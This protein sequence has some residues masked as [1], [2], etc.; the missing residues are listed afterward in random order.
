MPDGKGK[1]L[2]MPYIAAAIL[3]TAAI[4]LP[5]CAGPADGGP[6]RVSVA[7]IKGPSAIGMALF[8]DGAAEGYDCE[9]YTTADEVVPRLAKGELDIAAVPANLSSIL[10][11]N[12]EGGVRV[13]AI[14]TMGMTYV[15]ERGDSV[16]SLADL[17]GK[18]VYAGFKGK[19][20]EFDLYHILMGNGIDPEGDLTIEWKSEHSECVAALSAVDGAV[21]VLPQ[22]F[23][24][25]ALMADGEAR[26]AVDLNAEWDKL[27]SASGAPFPLVTGVVVVRAGFADEWPELVSEFLD[28]YKESVRM[29]ASDP[30][31]AAAAVAAKGVFPE[32]LALAAIPLCNVTFVEGSE[33]K[34][35]LGGYLGILYRL[36]PQ[37][38][39]GAL[40]GDDFYHIR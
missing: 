3:L 9:V 16:R 20:P 5:S 30:G 34:E 19:S 11:A 38:I 32:D 26:I 7:A 33:M 10:Y 35:G 40:P 14:G 29:V 31:W 21:A 8:L 22:P 2:A 18:V 37:S 17:R 15:V 39:G 28:L 36:N 23:A 25:A 12:T 24:A 13:I 6:M 1:A 27:Q 4:A